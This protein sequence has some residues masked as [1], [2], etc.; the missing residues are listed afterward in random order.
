[1]HN[2]RGTGEIGIVIGVS[3]GSVGVA[4]VLDLSVP[5]SAFSLALFVILS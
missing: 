4:C 1:M 5:G 3:N 2:G